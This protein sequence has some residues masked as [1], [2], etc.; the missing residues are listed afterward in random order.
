[1]ALSRS[2][3]GVVKQ[4]LPVAS[5]TSYTAGVEHDPALGTKCPW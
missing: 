3:Y 2:R 1:M 4:K 5:R